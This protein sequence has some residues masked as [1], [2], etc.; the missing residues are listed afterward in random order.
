M[1]TDQRAFNWQNFAL[2]RLQLKFAFIIRPNILLTVKIFRL[3]GYWVQTLQWDCS[4]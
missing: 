2:G 1:N 3:L 4:L